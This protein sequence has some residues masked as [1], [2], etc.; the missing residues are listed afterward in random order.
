VNVRA[1]V[2]QF[3]RQQRPAGGRANGSAPAFL[4]EVT[5]IV[6]GAAILYSHVVN[7]SLPP[8]ASRDRRPSFFSRG[9]FLRRLGLDA[10]LVAVATQAFDFQRRIGGCTHELANIFGAVAGEPLIEPDRANPTGDNQVAE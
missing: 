7:L 3:V 8:V 2:R 9:D 5:A 6:I 4:I 1:A 10:I